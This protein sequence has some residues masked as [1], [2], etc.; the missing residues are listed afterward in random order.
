M[1]IKLT[2]TCGTKYA[3]EVEPYR[4]GMPTR[5]ACPNCGADGTHAANEY[6]A[7]ALQAGTAAP[8]P[9]VT[10]RPVAST[11]P[12][13]PPP[14]PAAPAGLRI[15]KTHAPPAN[16]PPEAPVTHSAPAPRH[17]PGIVV[18]DDEPKSNSHWKGL[19]ATLVT[20]VLVALGAWKFG[21][22]WYNRLK[23]VTEIAQIA[24]EASVSGGDAPAEPQNLTE[25]DCVVLFVKHTNH[26]E[27][28]DAF[29]SYWREKY[30]KSVS[31][32][33]IE[34]EEWQPGE[35]QVFHAHNGYV[36]IIGSLEWPQSQYE[37]LAVHFSQHFNT[38]VFETRDVDFS[39]AYHFGV[40][41]Q[42]ARKFHAQMDFVP[43]ND[44][45]EEVVTTEG[46]DWALAH[47]FKPGDEGFKG[48]HMGDADKITQKLGM[49]MY[50][51]QPSDE[52]TP[53]LLREFG[54]KPKPP[55]RTMPRISGGD[56][57][58]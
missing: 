25:D 35:Y 23:A 7:H 40:Y 6:I 1:E 10:P 49:K 11:P 56:E 22:K 12:P 28:A 39:G 50:D 5:I 41:E 15:S 9:I 8:I 47:G 31:I 38:L 54:V 30:K 51:H 46:N 4:G 57:M 3:F 52:Q 43:K 2:C 17:V 26:L 13:P 32:N 33:K 19:V 58:D 24:G 20:L 55:Q 34:A 36:R 44:T 21:A 37:D 16:P 14:P 42:G 29:V 27:V 18:D 53:I 45:A 48:F